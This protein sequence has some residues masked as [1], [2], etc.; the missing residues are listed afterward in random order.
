MVKI[1]FDEIILLKERKE[2]AFIDTAI[3]Q[4]NVNPPLS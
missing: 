2:K 4:Q 1:M 3:V